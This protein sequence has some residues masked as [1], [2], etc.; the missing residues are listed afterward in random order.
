MVLFR[1]RWL[2]FQQD[3]PWPLAKQRPHHS[4]SCFPSNPTSVHP[5]PSSKRI[6][7]IGNEEKRFNNKPNRNI[8]QWT[9]LKTFETW[10]LSVSSDAGLH[11]L[12]LQCARKTV[13]ADNESKLSYPIQTSPIV[14]LFPS[15][16]RSISPRWT[17]KCSENICD[18]LRP[19][20]NLDCCAFLPKLMTTFNQ[21]FPTPHCSKYKC[22]D[23][24]GEIDG[25]I[26]GIIRR[27]FTQCQFYPKSSQQ[28]DNHSQLSWRKR[29]GERRVCYLICPLFGHPSPLLI[30]CKCSNWQQLLGLS[31]QTNE[32]KCPV[33]ISPTQSHSAHSSRERENRNLAFVTISQ[34]EIVNLF[35]SDTT[36]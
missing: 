21:I 32:R 13:W 14:L 7:Q 23:I 18:S 36:F 4:C 11:K 31:D 15:P 5:F 29:G 26:M 35:H 16:L 8:I 1:W 30:N 34:V 12:Q 3:V 9:G 22:N 17:N 24:Y 20:G 6:Y 19:K 33:C 10:G 2:F 27:Q 28:G 25:H